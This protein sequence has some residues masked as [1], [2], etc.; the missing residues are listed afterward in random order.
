MALPSTSALV[1][2]QAVITSAQCRAARALLAM[3]QAELATLAGVSALAIKRFE[4]GSD[5]RASTRDRIERA[6]IDAGVVLIEAGVVSPADAGP[7]VRLA[8]VD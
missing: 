2:Y 7:G 6:V 8:K 5:P 4:K 1:Y 3:T